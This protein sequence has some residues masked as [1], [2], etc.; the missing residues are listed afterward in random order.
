MFVMES[1]FNPVIIGFSCFQVGIM[2]NLFLDLGFSIFPFGNVRSDFIEHPI[3]Y[4]NPLSI[5]RI[6][7]DVVLVQ[8]TSGILLNTME[9]YIVF[10]KK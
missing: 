9:D 4:L 1:A 8:T 5:L 3:R 2:G 7:F 6:V 10:L